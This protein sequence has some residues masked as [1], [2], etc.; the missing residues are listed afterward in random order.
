MIKMLTAYTEEIDEIDDAVNEILEQLDLKNNLAANSIGLIACDPEFVQSGAAAA[1]SKK[2]PFD[3]AG[4]TTRAGAAR[5]VFSALMFSVSVLTSDDVKFSV[6]RSRRINSENVD[7]VIYSA[8][9]EGLEK[10]PG[11]PELVLAYPPLITTLGGYPM[12]NAIFRAAGNTPVFGT[13]SCS[14]FA[15][16]RNNFTI[17]NGDAEKDSAVMVLLSG[18]VH[19]DFFMVSIPTHSLQK[20]YG[21]ITKS[22]GCHVHT[23]NDMDFTSYLEKQGF[24]ESN[25]NDDS[26]YL[27]PFMINFGDGSL[28]IARALYSINDKGDAVFGSEM[29][30]G[31]TISL[32]SLN[33]DGIMETAGELLRQISSKKNINGILFYSCLV[34][35][36][37]LGVKNDDELKKII[38]AI[39]D[40][41]P[42]QIC[43]SGGEICPVRNDSGEFVNRAHNYSLIACVF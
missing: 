21:I 1:I 22:K 18:D 14:P 29:P 20:Q 31:K 19:P 25:I 12:G 15:D 37:L 4:I 7:E 13:L 23:V 41:A 24:S 8:Y 5:G 30:E 3:T 38:H 26:M 40:A 42:Y 35:H 28:P 39:D 43:Y 16:H 6:V 33:Y 36:I 17:L 34:R 11:K 27:I 32:G 9:T 2:L 10:L